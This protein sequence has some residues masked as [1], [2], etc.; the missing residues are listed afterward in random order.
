MLPGRAPRAERKA[1]CVPANFEYWTA[2]FPVGLEGFSDLDHDELNAIADQ[3]WEPFQMSAVHGGFA[4]V[5]LFRRELEPS[6]RSGPAPK[7]A[8]KTAKKSAAKKA[9]GARR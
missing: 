1:A 2:V 5:V 3:G 8:S 6:P 4:V 9:S 7:T